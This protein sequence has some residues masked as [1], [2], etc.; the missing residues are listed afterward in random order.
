MTLNYRIHW[1]DDSTE[2]AE[3]VRD[4][5][6]EHFESA[7]V[8]IHAEIVDDGE[9]IEDTAFSEALDLFVLDYNLD[10][11]N[12]DEL[13]KILR[14]NGELTEI[15][16]YSQDGSVCEKFPSEEGIHTCIRED[17]G[18]K[19]R[20]VV[21]RFIDRSRN[22]AVMRGMIISEAIDLENRLTSIVVDMF[23]DKKQLFQ[24]KILNKPLL[25]FEKKRMFLQ[26][27]LKDALK[28]ARDS[29]QKDE[30]KI[31]KLDRLTKSLNSFKEEIIDQRNI[32]AHSN[33]TFESGVLKLTPLIKGS[34]IVFD[35]AWKNSVR[36]NIKKHMRNLHEIRG[37]LL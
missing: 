7:E 36:E 29:E 15:V 26:S 17:A 4:G 3:S 16:F 10:G 8:N 11:R 37:V 9:D 24:D 2:F 27:V 1:V 20:T 18:E 28:E 13:I 35:N 30:A 31:E 22:V 33:K 21:D 12:G 5:I 19:I 23:G 34:A 25:D 14:S 32:L 6:V